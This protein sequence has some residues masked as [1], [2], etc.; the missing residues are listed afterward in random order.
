MF[1]PHYMLEKMLQSQSKLLGNL[2]VFPLS[3]C[4]SKGL[5]NLTAINNIGRERGERREGKKAFSRSVPIFF[6]EDCSIMN[7]SLKF[8]TTKHMRK[9]SSC[10]L[11]LLGVEI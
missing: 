2:T 5:D 3:Q 11:A 1:L 7:K 9:L 6:V 4:W 10:I 8:T